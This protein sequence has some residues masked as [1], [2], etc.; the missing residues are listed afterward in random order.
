MTAQLCGTGNINVTTDGPEYSYPE[1]KNGHAKIGTQTWTA[2]YEST[3]SSLLGNCNVEATPVSIT[4]IWVDTLDNVIACIGDGVMDSELSAEYLPCIETGIVS[5]GYKAGT[6]YGVGQAIGGVPGQPSTWNTPNCPNGFWQD[7]CNAIATNEMHQPST[8]NILVI[9]G[10]NINLPGDATITEIVLDI[11]RGHGPAYHTGGVDDYS[12]VL[13][14]GS[15]TSANLAK[16]GHWPITAQPGNDV[17]RYILDNSLDLW[18]VNEVQSNTFQIEYVV[19]D[20]STGGSRDVWVDSVKISFVYSQPGVI[21]WYDEDPLNP[22]NHGEYLDEGLTYDPNAGYFNPSNPVEQ[23]KPYTFFANC[24]LDP[25]CF[26]PANFEISTSPVIGDVEYEICSGGT[27]TFVANSANTPPDFAPLGSTKYKWVVDNTSP[28]QLGSTDLTG[29]SE[30]TTGDATGMT[31]GTLINTTAISQIVIYHVTAHIGDC[32]TEFNV[33]LT[34][35]PKPVI[36]NKDAEVCSGNSFTITTAGDIA[37]TGTTYSWGAPAITPGG[38]GAVTGTTTG[39]EETTLTGLPSTLTNTTEVTQTVTY[40]VTASLGEDC[41][42][43]T[44]VVVVTVYPKIEI[45][46]A[47][48]GNNVVCPNTENEF[49]APELS[50]GNYQSGSYQWSVSGG[51]ATIEGDND[52]ATVEVLAGNCNTSFTLSFTAND[53]NGCL[54]ETATK[55]V[56]VKVVGTPEEFVE[57]EGEAAEIESTV[58]CIALAV[59][60]VLPIIKDACGNILT[61]PEPEITNDPNSIT[62][63]GE[64]IYTYVYTDCSEN[65]FEWT[66]TYTIERSTPPAEVGGPVETTDEVACLSA[67]V[68]PVLPVVKDICGTTLVA[69]TPDI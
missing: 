52:E 14:N 39:D 60:P 27:Y 69:P 15:K 17:G 61:A 11:Y 57:E 22:G 32:V 68:P 21:T 63:E 16:P 4:Y 47:I 66:Y 62:C 30:N 29:I 28:N 40:Q 9:T 5:G 2:T 46:G 54:L 33:T 50:S 19:Y 6:A 26:L 38:L 20:P 41:T 18:T 13:V 48:S 34:V 1:T 51:G 35:M 56:E 43:A 23:G 31:S 67:A 42:P 12:L 49:S 3:Y 44:F 45:Y 36:I 64:R 25:T 65:E 37:P 8:S 55:S 24:S 58:E 53:E 10:F 7:P 59:A